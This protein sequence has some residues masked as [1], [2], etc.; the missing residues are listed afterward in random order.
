[1]FDKDK[2]KNIKLLVYDFDGVMTDNKVYIDQNGNEFVQVNRADGLAISEIKKL[3]IDQIIISTEKNSV[4]LLRAKKLGIKCFHAVD[5]KK[6][7]L[8]R[9]CESNNLKL[10]NVAFVGNDINDLDALS[11][12]G[13]SLCPSDAHDKIKKNSNYILNSKG[14]DGVIRELFDLINDKNKF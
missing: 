12:V 8:I 2:L 1:M 10:T 9:Y 11:V 7:K 14:G 5:N 3:L 6:E 4:V 13:F